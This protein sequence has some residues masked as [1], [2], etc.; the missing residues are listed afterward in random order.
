MSGY[1]CEFMNQRHYNLENK[2]I[3]VRCRHE[4][5]VSERFVDRPRRSVQVYHWCKVHS[6]TVE[7]FG[8]AYNQQKGEA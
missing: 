1:K 7:R 2:L 8:G 5:T 6:Y 3:G 4:A